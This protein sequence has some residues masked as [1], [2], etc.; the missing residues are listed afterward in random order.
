MF[1]RGHSRVH[2]Q[3]FVFKFYLFGYLYSGDAKPGIIFGREVDTLSN[4]RRPIGDL[5]KQKIKQ[6]SKGRRIQ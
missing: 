5:K 2:L 3:A 6:K 1:C 4:G